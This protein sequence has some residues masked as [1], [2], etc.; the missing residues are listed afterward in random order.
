MNRTAML[1][2]NYG[3]FQVVW[4][5][6][7]LGGA[8]GQPLLGTGVAALVIALHLYLVPGPREELSLLVSV[9]LLGALLDS[10]LV[11]FG[12]LSFPSGQF[13]PA[14]APHWIIAMW[15]SFAT[16][17]NLS[18]GWLK[19]RYLLA[20]VLGVV[21]GP[22]AYYAGAELGGVLIQADIGLALGGVALNWAIAMPLVM[23]LATRFN[24]VEITRESS[25]PSGS[26]TV[27]RPG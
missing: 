27:S 22:M 21:A 17:L 24:G 8:N 11:S 16:V 15:M 20:L 4:F 9:G 26:A 5:A 25:L 10:L 19:G 3:L 13:H 6:C 23:Y 7:V 18:L 2:L 14:M 12:W 1:I